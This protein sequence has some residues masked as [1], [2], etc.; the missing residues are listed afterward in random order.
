MFEQL[1]QKIHTKTMLSLVK[2]IGIL[3]KMHPLSKTNNGK[4]KFAV[5]LLNTLELKNVVEM[6]RKNKN[7][8]VAEITTSMREKI[9]QK[10]LH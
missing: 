7:N 3:L 1:A 8:S 6:L 2:L 5:G 9:K 4:L 10:F